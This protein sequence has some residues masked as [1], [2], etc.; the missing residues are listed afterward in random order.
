VELARLE[1]RIITLED[2]RNPHM[3]RLV[4]LL[5]LPGDTVLPW[6][7]T[8]VVVWTP[9]SEE[10]IRGQLQ[11]ANPELLS[12]RAAIEAETHN[13]SLAGKAG[14]PDFTLGIDWTQTDRRDVPDLV[15]NGKDP[16]MARIAIR[17]PLWRGRVGAASREARARRTSAEE[18]LASRGNELGNEL[19]LLHFRYRDAD[20]K[21]RLYRDT[22]IPKGDQAMRATYSAF[23]SGDVGFLDVLDAERTLLEFSLS[24]ERSRADLV[25][26]LAGLAA[27]SGREMETQLE[28]P[29][30]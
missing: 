19:S 22:L 13:V 4:A 3:A 10:E 23:E 16:L 15:D 17:V 30:R 29:N 25:T 6:P 12:L 21:M 27:I 14:Y 9:D 7:E 20:R 11:E 28:E 18:R 2:Q 8:N 1:D 24:L 26:A 5:D